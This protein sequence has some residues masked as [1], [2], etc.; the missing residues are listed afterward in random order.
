MTTPESDTDR[1]E[2]LVQALPGLKV[3]HGIDEREAHRWDRALDPNAGLPMAV[4]LPQ[5]TEQVQ[6]VVRYAGA[7]SIPIVPRGA[8]SGLSGGASAVEGGIVVSMAQMT[9]VEIDPVTRMAFVEPGV[10]NADLKAAAAAVGLWYP[11]D[12]AS[13]GFSS[14]GGNV[15]TNAGGLCCVK[16]GLTTDYVLGL[17]VV[18][19]DG[20]A[21]DLGG[22]RLKEAA[23]LSLTKLFVGSEGTLG[24]ITRIVLR[25]VPQP[26]RSATM[27]A[28]FADLG[29]S[30]RAVL[31]VSSSTRASML[32]FMDNVAI[33]AVEDIHGYGLDR[34]AQAMVLAQSDQPGEAATREIEAIAAVC[35]EFGAQEVL[36]T[37]DRELGETYTA[38]RRGA[39]PAVETKGRLLLGDVGVP[40]PELGALVVGIAAISA[41]RDVII[42]VIA[43]AGDGNTHP[44]VV[45]DPD[46][47][48]QAVRAEVA[49]GEVMDLAIRLG[50][51]ITGEHGVGRTKKAWL[52]GYVG[53]DVLRLNRTIKDAL[54]P[55]GLLNPGAIL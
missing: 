11:P 40:V 14:I 37:T 24:I 53:E 4:V 15:A 45:F 1:I 7:R 52:P 34:T 10:I 47:A 19:A 50:G 12:P 2:E 25:L 18:L 21:V 51:T 17:T 32:E 16:Y 31:A 26:P 8:G 27:V 35:R 22:P 28:T 30:C 9:H 6:Q 55:N 48:D 5:T 42:S 3:L 39:I 23:G 44:L 36:V 54:D 38:A 46:D 43:H 33:N 13:F 20:T 29:A 49:Y 41:A